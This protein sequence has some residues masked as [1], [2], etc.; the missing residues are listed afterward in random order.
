M[1]HFY[2]YI[3]CLLWCSA[4][5]WHVSSDRAG[6]IGG[7][8]GVRAGGVMDVWGVLCFVCFVVVDRKGF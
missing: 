8:G 1:I 6:S 3:G 7:S 4:V 2:I 5:S